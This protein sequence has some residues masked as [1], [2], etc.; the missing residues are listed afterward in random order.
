MQDLAIVIPAYKAEYLA[1]TLESILNQSNKDF[2]LYIGD[3]RSPYNLFDIVEKFSGKINLVYHR[4]ESNMGSF[5]LIGQWERCIELTK[6][7][8]WIWLFSDDDIMQPNCIERF[9]ATLQKTNS[10]YDLYRFNTNRI[11]HLNN[12]I[13]QATNNPPW[14]S[15]ADFLNRKL[16]RQTNSYAVEYIFNRKVYE[17]NKGFVKFPSA[18]ASD[19]AT[20]ALF[21]RQN[22]IYT[23]PNSFIK[24]RCSGQNLSGKH[25]PKL[26]HQK[27]DAVIQFVNWCNQNFSHEVSDKVLLNW[28]LFQFRLLK[29][30]N[31]L[32]KTAFL[33][34]ILS[35]TKI[36][37]SSFMIHFLKS[38]RN[39][40]SRIIHKYL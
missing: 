34:K 28:S 12:T 6:N 7:E 3:D 32:H 18:W 35:K 14:E 33:I 23:I 20:W 22:G 40:L 9:F 30:L 37:I 11:D 13:G 38:L 15:S 2:T 39:S 16:S 8:E 36:G 24:W 31:F 25:D 27:L 26:S 17:N 4:F 21:G 1:Y 19:D 10:Q 5:D 29:N